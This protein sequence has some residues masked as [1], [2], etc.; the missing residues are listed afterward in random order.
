FGGDLLL[1]VDANAAYTL[2][3]AGH[4]AGLDTFGLLLIE[5][6]LA[7]DDLAGRAERAGR[8]APPVCLD[9]SITSAKAAVDAVAMGACRIVNV[10]A[11]R[12][13]GYLEARRLHDPCR[14][15]GVPRW[16]GGM[17]ET[18]LGRAA[19]VA[20]AALPGFT[21]PGDT[22]ASDRYYRQDLTAPFVLEG[23]HLAVPLCPRIGV[24]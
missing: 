19:N 22:S 11:G 20:L 9:E 13:G 14:P 3:D 21:L 24:E 7:E 18:A 4:L 10:K 16:C 5:Q 1:Q 12:V 8:L 2:A 15:R 23:G 6:P 17:P